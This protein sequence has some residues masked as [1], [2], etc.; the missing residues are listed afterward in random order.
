[1][2]ENLIIQVG[3]E[4]KTDHFDYKKVKEVLHYVSCSDLEVVFLDEVT[5]NDANNV[6]VKIFDVLYSA[7]VKT[8]DDIIRQCIC[9]QHCYSRGYMRWINIKN[10]FGC[11]HVLINYNKYVERMTRLKL[12]PLEYINYVANMIRQ[13]S[14]NI[15]T[16][17][18]NFSLIEFDEYLAS[19]KIKIIK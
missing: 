12:E 6:V 18:M 11:N 9:Y 17:E 4:L 5:T 1:M 10:V 14:R 15:N 13:V 7:I 3:N 2:E 19:K 8:E 16:F